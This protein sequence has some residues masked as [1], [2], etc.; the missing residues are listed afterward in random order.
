MNNLTTDTLMIKKHA[1]NIKYAT[2]PAFFPDALA[3]ARKKCGY[4]A[5]FFSLWFIQ[6]DAKL[7]SRL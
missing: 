3:D 5:Y 2:I 6:C 4:G 1:Y 7:K